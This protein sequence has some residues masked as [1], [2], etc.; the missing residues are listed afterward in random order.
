MEEILRKLQ[1]DASGH[2]HKAIRDA[3][4]HACG[5]SAGASRLSGCRG[6]KGRGGN[7]RL[8]TPAGFKG[9]ESSYTNPTGPHRKQCYRNITKKRDT[10]RKIS[11]SDKL[12]IYLRWSAPKTDSGVERG[13]PCPC[14]G[15]ELHHPKLHWLFFRCKL[16]GINAHS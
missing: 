10:L 4:V 12:R 13:F 11:V 7:L 14:A 9:T 5:E 15:R 1:K 16:L 2:K 3:C 8:C 6:V